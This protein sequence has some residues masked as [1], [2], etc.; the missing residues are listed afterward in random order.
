[1]LPVSYPRFQFHQIFALDLGRAPRGDETVGEMAW[2]S[3]LPV[4]AKQYTL[5]EGQGSPVKD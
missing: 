2:G 1:M 4:L 5:A 3:A